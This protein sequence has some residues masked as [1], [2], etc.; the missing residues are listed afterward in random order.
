MNSRHSRIVRSYPPTGLQCE[1]FRH[2]A[3]LNEQPE[4]VHVELFEKFEGEMLKQR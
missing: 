1:I 4:H 3:I 2:E